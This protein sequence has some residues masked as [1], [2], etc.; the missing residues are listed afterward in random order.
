MHAY[1]WTRVTLYYQLTLIQK[2]T[3]EHFHDVPQKFTHKL[4]VMF[5]LQAVNVA[6]SMCQWKQ[7]QTD[8]Q[9]D[10]EVTTVT[11][12]LSQVIC[13]DKG[14]NTDTKVFSQKS[15]CLPLSSALSKCFCSV[16]PELSNIHK[17]PSIDLHSFAVSHH[18]SSA[19]TTVIT[20]INKKRQSDSWLQYKSLKVWVASQNFRQQFML[21]LGACRMVF[22]HF[23]LVSV[24]VWFGSGLEDLYAISI[25]FYEARS[26]TPSYRDCQRSSL[27]QLN[28]L[29]YFFVKFKEIYLL[30]ELSN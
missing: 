27:L 30:L 19:A 12:G 23:S 18:I 25:F 26:M 17:R 13:S 7:R 6:K 29:P 9:T 3:H 16:Q 1:T 10:D 21:P 8:R 15:N 14:M 22:C 20:T 2:N 24:S 4:N 11:A 28:D 5:T